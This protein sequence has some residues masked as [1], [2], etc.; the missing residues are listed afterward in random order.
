[1]N[2]GEGSGAYQSSII[3][4]I[5]NRMVLAQKFRSERKRTDLYFSHGTDEIFAVSHT[6]LEWSCP[7]RNEISCRIVK[8]KPVFTNQVIYGP[9]NRG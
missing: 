4:C 1:M 6:I 8:Y 2:Q 5:S 9:P 3:H 7:V